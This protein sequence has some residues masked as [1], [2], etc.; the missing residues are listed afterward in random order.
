MSNQQPRNGFNDYPVAR[1][2]SICFKVPSIP[3]G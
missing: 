2:R 1:S 3:L